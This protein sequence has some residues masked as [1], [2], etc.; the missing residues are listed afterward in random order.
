MNTDV[1]SMN[2]FTLKARMIKIKFKIRLRHSYI[3]DFN[4]QVAQTYMVICIYIWAIYII[5]LYTFS[6]IFWNGHPQPFVTPCICVTFD[7]V[8]NSCQ[9]ASLFSSRSVWQLAVVSVWTLSTQK[10]TCQRWRFKTPKANR[11]HLSRLTFLD[12]ALV[13]FLGTCSVTKTHTSVRVKKKSGVKDKSFYC[14][15]FW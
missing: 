13:S 10:G 7:D 11:C 14:T 5:I 1:V 2:I 6:F 15:C 3:L 12:F 8:W 4:K 9:K